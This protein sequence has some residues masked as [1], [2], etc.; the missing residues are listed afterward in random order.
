MTDFFC[1]NYPFTAHQTCFLKAQDP[2][3]NAMAIIALRIWNT[4]ILDFENH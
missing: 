2:H 3:W 4:N 1:L